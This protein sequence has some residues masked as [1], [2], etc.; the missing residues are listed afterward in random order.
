MHQ[1]SKSFAYGVITSIL[2]MHFQVSG[3]RNHMV[4]SSGG[5]IIRVDSRVDST[6]RRPLT[7]Q[8]KIDL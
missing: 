3:K 1:K 6:D 4:Y 5:T 7:D 2:I 8:R